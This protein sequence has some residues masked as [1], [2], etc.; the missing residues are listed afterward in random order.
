MP[1][2]ASRNV[3]DDDVHNAFDVHD[4]AA[5]RKAWILQQLADGVELKAA[6]VA[7]NFKCSV[8]TAY[9]DL[10]ALKTEGKIEYIGAA[11]TGYFRLKQH[12]NG[13]SEAMHRAT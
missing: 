8:K 7:D 9:H 13:G 2:P 4:D 10:D 5:L 1:L 12:P 6:S 11:R 3:H